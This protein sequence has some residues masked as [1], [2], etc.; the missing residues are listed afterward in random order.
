MGSTAGTEFLGSIQNVFEE[1]QGQGFSSVTEF[2]KVTGSILKFLRACRKMTGARA[3]AS[4]PICLP[5]GLN[6]RTHVALPP[7][8]LK[9]NRETTRRLREAHSSN[10]FCGILLSQ[11]HEQLHAKRSDLGKGGGNM[12]TSAGSRRPISKKKR[13]SKRSPEPTPNPP[14]AKKARRRHKTVQTPPGSGNHDHKAGASRTAGDGDGV[15]VSMTPVSAIGSKQ[16]PGAVVT[17]TQTGEKTGRAMHRQLTKSPTKAPRPAKSS[18]SPENAEMVAARNYGPLTPVKRL[19]IVLPKRKREPEQQQVIQQQQQKQ[20]A[21][22]T[23]TSQD[24]GPYS[25]SSSDERDSMSDISEISDCMIPMD[26][27]PSE[28]VAREKTKERGL[29]MAQKDQ[30]TQQTRQEP[31]QSAAATQFL[32]MVPHLRDGISSVTPT[33]WSRCTRR[34]QRYANSEGIRGADFK[35]RL[36]RLVEIVYL[37][38]E[39]ELCSVIAETLGPEDEVVDY[40]T[41]NRWIKEKNEDINSLKML[42]EGIDFSA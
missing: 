19:R 12:T 7:T 26:L 5:D 41:R 32:R 14:S 15:A 10:E 38:E 2:R 13:A 40:E 1:A 4:C 20:A 25:D 24:D 16:G 3:R 22:S 27:D 9:L 39:L 18:A 6:V 8:A 33:N 23:I 37:P 35:Q 11:V 34:I 36:M 17:K 30:S 42:F 29:Q 28:D 31:V 21:P